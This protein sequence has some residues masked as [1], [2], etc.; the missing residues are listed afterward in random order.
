MHVCLCSLFVVGGF[1]EGAAILMIS[2]PELNDSIQS[3]FV[4]DMHKEKVGWRVG[5]LLPVP[6]GA[7]KIIF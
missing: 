3:G 5:V 7:Q 4:L 2:S 6:Q 1:A